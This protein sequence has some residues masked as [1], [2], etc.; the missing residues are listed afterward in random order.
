[1]GEAFELDERLTILGHQLSAGDLAP[2]FVL[3]S[4]DPETQAMQVVRLTDA[5]GRV[6]LPLRRGLQLDMER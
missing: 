1:V 5:G 3:E 6:R 2:D 4:F